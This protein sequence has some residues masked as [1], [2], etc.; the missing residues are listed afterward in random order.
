MNMATLDDDKQIIL[1]TKNTEHKIIQKTQN[2]SDTEPRDARE[3]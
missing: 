3:G 1:T 2:M